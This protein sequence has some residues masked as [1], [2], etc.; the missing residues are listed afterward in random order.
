MEHTEFENTKKTPKKYTCESCSFFTRKLTDYKRHLI[1][2]KHE[3]NIVK[4]IETNVVSNIE[5]KVDSKTDTD[6]C[7]ICNH[8]FGS[9]T[10]LWR[11]KKKC[12]GDKKT[13]E[14]ENR[15]QNILKLLEANTLILKQNTQL[16]EM[17][18][19]EAL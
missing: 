11:H 16:I 12:K 19:L 18:K 4:Q 2:S 17:Y 13:L 10:T 9:R 7:E 1:T 3:M 15:K 5:E 6:L 8:C 14:N